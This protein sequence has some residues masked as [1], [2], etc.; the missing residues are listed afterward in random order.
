METLIQPVNPWMMGPEGQTTESP[1]QPE[2]SFNE[3]LLKQNVPVEENKG[4]GQEII[5]AAFFLNLPSILPNLSG[6]NELND[7]NLVNVQLPGQP[8]KQEEEVVQN[9][10]AS[11][12][13]SLVEG[14]AG[15]KQL[16]ADSPIGPAMENSEPNMESSPNGLSKP[17]STLATS[18]HLPDFPEILDLKASFTPIDQVPGDPFSNFNEWSEQNLKFLNQPELQRDPKNFQWAKENFPWNK[19]PNPSPEQ[20]ASIPMQI[21]GKGVQPNGNFPRAEVRF[22]FLEDKGERSSWQ[23]NP[24]IFGEG[25]GNFPPTQNITGG[26]F[27]ESTLEKELEEA[28]IF[29]REKSD[30]KLNSPTDHQPRQESYDVYNLP[31]GPKPTTISE[32]MGIQQKPQLAKGGQVPRFEHIVE[33]VI[34]AIRNN[35]ERIRLTLDPPHLGNLYVEIRKEKEEINA[36][37]WAD[38]PLTKEILES[39]QLQLRKLLEADG[40]KLG[41]YE[42]FVQKD[43]GSF[44]RNDENDFPRGHGTTPS[45]EIKESELVQALEILPGSIVVAGGSKYIDR[46]I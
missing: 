11:V 9:Q 10:E 12:I 42:V 36:T 16:F 35:E 8:L 1:R 30:P 13:L 5:A 34:W 43:T 20:A 46:F 45:L 32:E 38:N 22:D 28:V 4:Q 3:I 2:Q 39:N 24:Q 31:G 7:L 40:F 15:P 27:L 6:R 25:E 44:R 19:S 33:R 18:S 23:S 17:D 14:I 29:P 41:K 26:G 21:D 37:L